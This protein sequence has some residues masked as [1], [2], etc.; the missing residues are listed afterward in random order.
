MMAIITKGKCI[1]INSTAWVLS[2]T[3]R[4]FKKDSSDMVNLSLE[5]SLSLM[6]L[7]T[8]ALWKMGK[9]QAKVLFKE[10]MAF[11]TLDTLNTI[12]LMEMAKFITLTNQTSREPFK[13]AY[14]TEKDV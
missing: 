13:K 3:I 2:R 10:R 7:S 6:G 5:S 9:N 11:I 14:K 1:K 8:K 12:N 4:L